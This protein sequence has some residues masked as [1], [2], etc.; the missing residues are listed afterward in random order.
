MSVSH[1]P[2]TLRALPW[3]PGQAAVLASA[4]LAGDGQEVC[5]GNLPGWPTPALH[6]CRPG[7]CDGSRAVELST[8][9]HAADSALFEALMAVEKYSLS[10]QSRAVRHVQSSS[11][12]QLEVIVKHPASQ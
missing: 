4:L 8:R 3:R 6:Q 10:S 2:A 5:L 9:N 7:H 1:R 12:L 11:L